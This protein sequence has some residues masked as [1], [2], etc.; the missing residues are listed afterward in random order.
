MTIEQ[1]TEKFKKRYCA[2]RL[3]FQPGDTEYIRL[4]AKIEVLKDPTRKN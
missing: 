1:R 3:K 2:R 4:T